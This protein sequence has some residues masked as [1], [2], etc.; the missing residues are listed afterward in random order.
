MLNLHEFRAPE[1]RATAEQ[2][3]LP[4]TSV[5]VCE[6]WS[7]RER[8]RITGKPNDMKTLVV[9]PFYKKDDAPVSDATE[10]FRSKIAGS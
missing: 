6:L 1:S 2:K 5:E 10:A 9:V 4:L 7:S 8:L 3:F